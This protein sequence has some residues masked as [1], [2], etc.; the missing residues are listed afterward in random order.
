MKGHSTKY[1]TRNPH[2]GQGHHKQECLRNC[3]RKEKCKK[4][5]LLD[6]TWCP[7]WDPGT[8]KGQLGENEEM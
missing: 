8:E 2:N 5:R 3:H 6:V 1:L 7:E 4:T